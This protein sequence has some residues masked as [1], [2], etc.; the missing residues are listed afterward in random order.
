[1]SIIEKALQKLHEAGQLTPAVRLPPPPI[2]DVDSIEV[3]EIPGSPQ[4]GNIDGKSVTRPARIAIDFARLRSVGVLA[5]ETCAARVEDEY[6]RIKWPLLHNVIGQDSA[7]VPDGNLIM[8]ASSLPGEGKTTTA[9]NLAMSFAQE[10]DCTVLLVD[11][12]VAKPHISDIFGLKDQAGLIDLLLDD[13]LDVSDVLVRT[14]NEALRILAA[15]SR[16]RG[17]PE[18]LA[19][20]RMKSVIGELASRYS[21][22]IIVFDSAPLLETNEAQVL[23]GLVGQIVLVVQADKTPQPA[24]QE[25]VGFLDTTKAIN[26]VL[27]QSRTLPGSHYHGGY[28]GY[29]KTDRRS[30]KR[31][32][33]NWT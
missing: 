21:D 28:Y 29:K 12:D 18:L 32:P 31:Y 30:D 8:V 4:E 26:L 3:E 24:V 14:D 15:G 6:R 9:V 7:L 11:A 10:R 13:Q 19:S 5:P 20:N 16:Y 23:A 25:A 22:R 2:G 27:N 17:A 33:S 1:M